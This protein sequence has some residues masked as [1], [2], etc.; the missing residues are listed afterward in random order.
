MP[1]DRCRGCSKCGT[2]LVDMGFCGPEDHK[3]PAPHEFY[4]QQV[5]TN[6]GPKPLDRCRWCYRTRSQIE[7]GEP[8]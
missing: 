2:N 3:D 6:D 5:E 4:T 1:P 7:K 8:A